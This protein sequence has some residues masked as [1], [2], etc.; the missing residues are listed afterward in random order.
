MKGLHTAST[1]E[2]LGRLLASGGTDRRI[3]AARDGSLAGHRYT[4]PNSESA[5]GVGQRPLGVGNHQISSARS[6]GQTS[7]LRTCTV[8]CELCL[9]GDAQQALRG[10]PWWL[11][12][13]CDGSWAKVSRY[14]QVDSQQC[15]GSS[16]RCM[17][18]CSPARI[19]R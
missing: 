3:S 8:V 2:Q 7:S 19:Q 14:C 16:R 17:T 18:R 13:G 12:Q 9:E 10:K 5:P 11:G 6:W 1:S 15:S 4:T